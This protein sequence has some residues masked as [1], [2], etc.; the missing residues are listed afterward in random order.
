MDRKEKDYAYVQFPL[1]L[2]KETY[3]N[4]EKGLHMMIN[5]GIVN[6]AMKIKYNLFDVAKQLHYDYTRNREYLQDYIIDKLSECPD[7]LVDESQPGFDGVKGFKPDDDLAINPLLDLFKS[8]ETL[9]ESAILNYQIHIAISKDHL[10]LVK[11]SYAIIIDNYNKALSKQRYFESG[12][13]FPF[14]QDAMPYCKIDMIFDFIKNPKDID[15]LRAYI[16]INS[17]IG[18]RNFISTNKPAILSRM[19]GCKSKAIF[20]YYTTDKYNKDKNIL[21]TVERYSKR[22]QMDKLLLTLAERKYIM[23]LS[24]EKV[25]VIYLSKYMEPEALKDMIIQTKEKQNL[26]KRIKEAAANL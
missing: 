7:Y 20:E 18:R 1:C 23:F 15:L 22:Y 10:N 13:K 24:K 4:I 19:T 17:M 8:D 16:G 25:S 2:L 14:G 26:K 3:S 9:N 21:P 6:Y 12:Y 5:Y 11:L